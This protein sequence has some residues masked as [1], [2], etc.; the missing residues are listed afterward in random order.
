MARSNRWIQ[1]AIKRPGSLVAWFKR[2]RNKLKKLLGYDP[3]TRD[4][5]INDRAIL[6]V[7]RLWKEGKIKLRTRIVRK[8]Y[9]AKTLQKLR[10]REMA[11][12]KRR[13]RRRKK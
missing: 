10:K 11:K 3:I 8:L 2:H 1:K 5:D 6:G 4:G 9:L 12:R 7:L 13:R